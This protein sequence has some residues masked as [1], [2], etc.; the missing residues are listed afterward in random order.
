ML[1]FHHLKCKISVLI[2]A[3]KLHCGS[4][5]CC[6]CEL[7]N[8]VTSASGSY[9]DWVRA[10]RSMLP[11]DV[12]IRDVLQKTAEHVAKHGHSSFKKRN[13]CLMHKWCSVNSH[14]TV[15]TQI[16]IKI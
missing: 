3:Q 6:V 15:L 4:S 8:R 12:A 14:S 7:L 10:T 9:T 1:I 2:Q 16:A 5:E 11:H 13:N